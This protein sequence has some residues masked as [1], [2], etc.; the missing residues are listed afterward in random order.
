MLFQHSVF[1][2]A[3]EFVSVSL[4]ASSSFGTASNCRKLIYFFVSAEFGCIMD[5]AHPTIS[6]EFSVWSESS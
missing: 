4:H 2:L 1:L 3:F 5:V 6:V